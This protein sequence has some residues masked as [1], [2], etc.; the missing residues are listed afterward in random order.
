VSKAEVRRWLKR[1]REDIRDIEDAL[2]G[3]P[4]WSG[5]DEYAGDLSGAA[6]EIQNMAA[7]RLG[8]PD[9]TGTYV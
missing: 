2:D 1:C 5:V 6:A 8:T 7:V 4:D 3:E 9:V